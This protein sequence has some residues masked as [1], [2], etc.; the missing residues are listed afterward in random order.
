[1]KKMQYI[2][3]GVLGLSLM[4]TACSPAA[5]F[6]DTIKLENAENNVITVSA[7][8]EVKVVPDI[9]DII[10]GVQTEAADPLGCQSKNAE[11]INRVI[12][13]LKG[14]GIEE[15]KIQTTGYGL[16]PR[17]DWSQD[18]QQIIGYEMRTDIIVSGL[19]ID[20]VGKLISDSVAA[21]VNNIQSVSYKSSEYDARYQ[22]ALKLAIE[23]AKV[24]AETM[25]AA[26]GCSTDGI[27]HIEEFTAN[28]DLR[29]STMQKEAA[30]MDTGAGNQAAIMPG[31]LSVQAQVSVDFKI[32]K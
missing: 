25:A 3:A 24:K 19:P 30:V 7:S 21:G 17:Y 5:S 4:L 29:Y 16:N 1:M 6:P 27:V 2:T 31:E 23:A 32:V 26:G 15:T 22:E 10:Y 18:I 20:Q 14:L 8:E 13:L 11:D 28:Q 9:A 12:E